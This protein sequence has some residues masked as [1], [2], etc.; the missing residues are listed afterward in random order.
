M[1]RAWGIAALTIAV[2]LLVSVGVLVR[3]RAQTALS[4]ANSDVA[5]ERE[6]RFTLQSLGPAIDTGFEWVSAPSTFR[7]ADVY[8]NHFYIASS[9]G[10]FEYDERGN[11]LRDFRVGREL[12][13]SPLTQ[14]SQGTITGSQSR[15]LIIGTE[16]EGVLLFDG[17]TFRQIRPE[18][19]DARSVNALLPLRSGQLLIGTSKK[20]VLVFDG[21]K[22]TPFHDTLKNVHVTSMSGDEASLWVGTLADGAIHW[23]AGQV[24][25]FTESEGLPDIAVHSMTVNGN[26]AYAGTSAGV[27][28]FVDGKFKRVI[29]NGMFALS[30]YADSQQLFIGTIDEGMAEVPIDAPRLRAP[31]RSPL[32]DLNE[33]RQILRAGDAIYAVAPTG[34]YQRTKDALRWKRVLKQDAAMLADRNISAI[35]ADREGK[36]WVG[37]FDRGLDVVDSEGTRARHIENDHVFCVN[38]IVMDP[39]RRE[40]DVA[41]ANGLVLF[42][43]SGREQHVM[44]K[45]DGLMAE[46]VTDVVLR[47]DDKV[48]ATPAGLT[49]IDSAGARSLYAFHGLVNN[50]VYALAASGKRVVAGTLGG[51]S[52]MN[53]DQVITNLTTASSGLK[54]NWVTAIT[55]V[56]SDWFVGT[57]GA[58]VMRMTADGKVEPME[59]ATAPVEV[60]PNAM[61]TTKDHVLAGTLG[62]GLYVFDRKRQKWW[63]VTAG[64]PSMN[65]TAL[66]E[67]GGYIYVGTENGLIR[68]AE[69]RLQP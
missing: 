21:A 17:H 30:V 27:T 2:L 65:V 63:T 31:G 34:V 45:A 59:V 49:F 57:Y 28:E 52:L 32:N 3:W 51:I 13:P 25:K 60:N 44:G 40:I 41:T 56:D 22:I 16:T 48:L 55:Q 19:V 62:N 46:H 43:E 29:A 24:E 26:R 18:N 36:V 69:S 61:L 1:K 68:I 14:L 23:H 10:L 58:G 6:F 9:A 37:Y 64:L 35:A 12:P 66:A 53:D 50:H 42:D 8:Q 33:V 4:G 5:S 54:H 67:I 15:E 47:G 39:K 38:R 11:L 7:S 20:G